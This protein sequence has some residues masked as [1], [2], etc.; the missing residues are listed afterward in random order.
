[1]LESHQTHFTRRNQPAADHVDGV[2]RPFYFPPPE[3]QKAFQHRKFGRLV[4]VLPDITLQQR[5]I[6]GKA[7]DDFGGC[8]AEAL[9][10]LLKVFYQDRSLSPSVR[11]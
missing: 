10:L 8:E 1:M 3:R 5:G 11:W 2:Q 6:I 9:K 4:V 7:V